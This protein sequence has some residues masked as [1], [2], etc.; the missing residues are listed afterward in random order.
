MRFVQMIVWAFLLEMRNLWSFFLSFLELK[1]YN[2]LFVVNPVPFAIVLPF[3][4]SGEIRIRSVCRK[5]DCLGPPL[6]SHMFLGS[7]YRPSRRESSDSD[8]TF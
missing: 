4:A 2:Y 6:E 7:R 8:S 5:S 1:V 3:G